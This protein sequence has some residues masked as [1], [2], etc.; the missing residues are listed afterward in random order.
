MR[1]LSTTSAVWPT[2]ATATVVV[3]VVVVGFLEAP[4]HTLRPTH[5]SERVVP[6]VPVPTR[7]LAIPGERSD[8]L[9]TRGNNN[10]NN[11]N[12]NNNNNRTMPVVVP[13]ETA[14]RLMCQAMPPS[15][16]TTT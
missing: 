8:T 6:V 9:S 11:T 4:A 3:V 15:R 14:T 1:R 12:N 10:N 16:S 5:E 13:T 2:T 7:P